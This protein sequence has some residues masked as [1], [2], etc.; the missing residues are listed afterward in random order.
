M[1]RWMLATLLF[2]IAFLA[3]GCPNR[4]PERHRPPGQAVVQQGPFEVW[5]A[6]DGTLE[7]RN[8][9]PIMSRL[10]SATIVELAPDGARVREGDVLARFDNVQVERDLV[11][12][13]RDWK[14]ASA[15]LIALTNARIPLEIRDLETRLADALRQVSEEQQALADYT[16][17]L[18]EALIPEQEVRRQEL[19]LENAERAAASLKRQ[20]ALT[21]QFLHPAAIERAQAVLAAAEQELEAARRQ[22]SNCVVTAPSDGV[23]AYRS[24]NVGG[25]FRPVRVGDMV[26]RSQPFMALPDMS[27]LVMRCDVPESDLRLVQP[28]S[29]A[30]VQPIAYPGLVMTGEVESVASM[31]QIVPGRPDGTKYFGVLIRLAGDDERL[32]SGMT[33][34]ARI[35]S[36]RRETA[37][38]LPRAAV[39]WAGNDAFVRLAAP[40][41]DEERRIEVG[42]ANETEVEV[43]WGLRP[44]DAVRLP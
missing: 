33:A 19:K 31:A 13:E 17:L 15:E 39:R 16:E 4:R 42:M 24:V 5:S 35:R 25:E 36:Y 30:L 20:L 18:Q 22:W 3:A 29:L 6:Y 41:A 27:Q 14:L 12:L 9:R 28:G 26:Y 2:A 1:R 37:L 21:R 23:V 44:G 8:L 11:R 34:R 43:L 38:R 7:S 32:R 40:R 10:G